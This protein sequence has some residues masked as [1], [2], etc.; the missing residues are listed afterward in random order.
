M[1]EGHLLHHYAR[2]LHADLA[3]RAVAASS[4]QGRFD[5]RPFDGR[6]VERVHARGKHLFCEVQDAP[7][8]HVHLGHDGLLLRTD[9]PSLP[10]LRGT[11]LRLATE[12]AA[13]SLIAPSRCEPLTPAARDDVLASLGP[14]PVVDTGPAAREEA[15][16]RLTAKRSPVG[17]ALLDQSVW[18]G[19]GNVWRAELPHLLRIDPARR[20]DAE[21]AGR[22]WDLSVR[23]LGDC[24][25]PGKIITV[26]DGE[27]GERW[28]Y[29]RDRCRGCGAPVRVQQLGGRTCYTCP[30]EQ[31]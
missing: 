30:A 31:T 25:E 18:A 2:R 12:G 16:R 27:P 22:L 9:D 4:P 28:V 8:L 29:K 5:A 13:W 24:V 20:V 1:P 10:P 6:R 15:V 23:M 11:R 7:V 21:E 17:T 14:D 26:P 19:L 3:G